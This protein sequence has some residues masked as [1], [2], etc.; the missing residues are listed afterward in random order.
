MQ[1]HSL[2]PHHVMWVIHKGV[3]CI[4]PS[5]HKLLQA[6]VLNQ[7]ACTTIFTWH[8]LPLKCFKNA[9]STP[10]TTCFCYFGTFNTF[11]G[12]REA[13]SK[14]GANTAKAKEKWAQKEMPKQHMGGW[15]SCQSSTFGHMFLVFL[16]FATIHIT[17][18]YIIIYKAEQVRH[19]KAQKW[20]GV[21]L[22]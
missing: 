16:H 9:T 7:H 17:Y 19:I 18:L 13:S 15:T 14:I 21:C 6:N 2:G 22:F 10:Q 20:A 8:A 3:A 12:A 5:L 4:I 1:L 11:E